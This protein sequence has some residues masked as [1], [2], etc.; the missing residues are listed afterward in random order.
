MHK[1]EVTKFSGLIARELECTIKIL[2]HTHLL[3]KHI[4]VFLANLQKFPLLE[5]IQV[6]PFQITPNIAQL[7]EDL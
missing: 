7:H 4:E 1:I 2:K 6:K 3:I 5:P